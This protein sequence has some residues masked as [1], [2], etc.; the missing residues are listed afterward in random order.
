ME[1]HE[2]VPILVVE[3]NVFNDT[4]KAADVPR[5][6]FV[7]RNAAREEIYSWTAVP[8]RASL[9]PGEAVAFRSRLASPPTE[10]RDLI[11][12]FVNRRDLVAGTR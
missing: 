6:K 10:A 5:L 7:V 3:G 4:R 12:R 8:A 9:L 2:G 11:I 1:Q